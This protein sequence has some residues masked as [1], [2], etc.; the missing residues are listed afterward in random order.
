[1]AMVRG[2]GNGRT[3]STQ[4]LGSSGLATHPGK[5]C[6]FAEASPQG[7]Q[8]YRGVALQKKSGPTEPS[9]Q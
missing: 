4:N 8:P 3:Y 1:M 5:P 7:P 9:E 6:S 2:A